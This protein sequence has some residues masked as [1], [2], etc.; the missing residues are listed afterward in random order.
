[1]FIKGLVSKLQVLSVHMT[2]AGRSFN[3]ETDYAK[4]VEGVKQDDQAKELAKRAKN[5]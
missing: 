3:E 1:M 4:K 2:Y 5:F